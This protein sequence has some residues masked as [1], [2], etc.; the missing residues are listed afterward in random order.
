[1]LPPGMLSSSREV[2]F[3]CAIL[4]LAKK[5]YSFLEQTVKSLYKKVSPFCITTTAPINFF[6]IP[7]MKNSL[8]DL[9]QAVFPY[10]HKHINRNSC[11]TKQKHF[12]NELLSSAR[13]LAYS[14]P[15]PKL[16]FFAQF[17]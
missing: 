11:F 15:K 7:F 4:A 5:Q 10:S 3:D 8:C 6:G 13:D 1:M 14:K 16:M 9:V 17:Y 2:E 12:K